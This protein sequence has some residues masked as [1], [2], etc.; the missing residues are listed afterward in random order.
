[1]VRHFPLLQIPVTLA[2]AAVWQFEASLSEANCFC[3]GLLFVGA[4]VRPNMLKM[5]KTAFDN[6]Y[7]I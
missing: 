2:A 1:M 5:P 3:G 7:P 4:P 6:M